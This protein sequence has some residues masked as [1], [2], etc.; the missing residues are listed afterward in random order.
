MLR[1]RYYRSKTSHDWHL[2]RKQRNYVNSLKRVS[3]RNYFQNKCTI[4]SNSRDFWKTIS[5]F[6]CNR[7]RSNCN[8]SLLEN[9]HI[10]S[11]PLQVANIFNDF[12]INV[13][14]GQSEP[15]EISN[16]STEQIVEYYDEHQSVSLI[17]D[18]KLGHNVFSFQ[19]VDHTQVLKRLKALNVNKSVGYDRI[20]AKLLKTGAEVLCHSLTR[21]VNY[22]FS[23]SVFPDVLKNAELSPMFKKD[24]CF[25]KNNYRPVSLLTIISKVVEGLMCDQ[26]NNFFND[27]LCKN[28]AA[29]RKQYSCENV[30]IQCVENWKLALDN[31]KTVGCLLM[32]LSKAF[33]SI[34]HGL[35]VSKLFQYGFTIDASNMVRSYLCDRPQRVKIGNSYSEWKMLERGVPQ[36]SLVGPTLFNI[37]INDFLLLLNQKCQVYNYADDNT[38]A[39]CDTDPLVVKSKLEHVSSVSISWFRNNYMQV[40]P[41][42]FQC[43]VLSRQNCDIV[44]NIDGAVVKPVNVVKLLGFHIDHKLNF[45]E[46]VKQLI[47]K[48]SRQVNVLGRLSTKLNTKTKLHIIRSLILANFKYCN[49]VYHYCS[50]KDARK[51]ERILE[52]ALKYAFHEFDC[53]YQELLTRANLPSL[54]LDRVRNVLLNVHKVIKNALPPVDGLFVENVTPYDLRN[55]HLVQPMCNTASYG[56]KSLRYNGA[57]LY[58]KLEDN[59]RMLN[60]SDFKQYI[61]T[62]KCNCRNCYAC[63]F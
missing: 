44:F 52:R 50:V 62:W 9:D 30:I 60:I 11:N 16:M 57:T 55:K 53:S 56:S 49:T 63:N 12:F 47:V 29:Y 17:K 58:N 31:G 15:D 34:P 35:L 21:I 7:D 39:F 40:N 25:R 46:H 32:D 45:S 38:I 43:I 36:G 54:F 37:F 24:D 3:I 33:D 26:L 48:C 6:I 1:R 10:V 41:S 14:K 20:P 51:I 19:N 8:I 42:K 28:L 27:I 59:F 13:T 18:Q 61:K 23:N 4:S 2:F 5:P 22:S